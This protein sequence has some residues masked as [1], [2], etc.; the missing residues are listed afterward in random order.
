[1]ERE[2]SSYQRIPVQELIDALEAAEAAS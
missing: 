1:M 2:A